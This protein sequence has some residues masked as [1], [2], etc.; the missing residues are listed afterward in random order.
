M[1]ETK[2][3]IKI[4]IGCETLTNWYNNLKEGDEVLEL[5]EGKLYRRYVISMNP[6]F[7]FLTGS[8]DGGPSG[9][10]CYSREWIESVVKSGRL[11]KQTIYPLEGPHR[12]LYEEGRMSLKIQKEIRRK[13]DNL[14]LKTLPSLIQVYKA[15]EQLE[16]TQ[17]IN[18][19]IHDRTWEDVAS[20]TPCPACGGMKFTAYKID[21]LVQ[22]TFCIGCGELQA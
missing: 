3:G 11:E 18:V 6:G 9:A 2:Q 12:R 20:D 10:G 15:L 13:L 8:S 5:F 19:Q 14:G 4:D 21:G 16:E 1:H 17:V 22:S 7:I